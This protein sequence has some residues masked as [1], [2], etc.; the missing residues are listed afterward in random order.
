MEDKNV[1]VVLDQSEEVEEVENAEEVKKKLKTKCKKRLLL[2][3]EVDE[4]VKSRLAREKKEQ[5]EAKKLAKMNAE[6]KAMHMSKQK[7]EEL[8]KR[9]TEL[10]KREL[11]AE[12]K[13][14][15]SDKGLSPSL[16]SVLSYTDAE[17]CKESID[18]LAEAISEEVQRQVE[19]KLKGNAPIKKASGPTKVDPG[20]PLRVQEQRGYSFCDFLE[21][22]ITPACAGTT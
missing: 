5:D 15:L 10:V 14:I 21:L 8:K 3:K 1:D 9:E 6:G 13:E 16:A 18:I 17:S 12:A 7:E 11:T 4:I 19:N 2:K 20:S 22:G